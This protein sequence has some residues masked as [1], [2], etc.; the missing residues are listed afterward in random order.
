M[1][2]S[3]WAD[4]QTG[5]LGLDG[6]ILFRSIYT[7]N[8]DI[9]FLPRTTR[10]ITHPHFWSLPTP[11]QSLWS[12]LYYFWLYIR[13]HWNIVVNSQTNHWES[14]HLPWAPRGFS[15]DQ[16]Q[17][18]ISASGNGSIPAQKFLWLNLNWT[19]QFRSGQIHCWT[20]GIT[21]AI[22]YFRIVYL[23]WH[24]CSHSTVFMYFLLYH[25]NVH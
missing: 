19:G 6:L 23:L 14:I 2:W 13:L 21:D 9:T 12:K 8:F 4:L 25:S 1:G 5:S 16:A 15:P 22:L 7:Y 24:F 18:S 3:D 10:N 17:C 11:K 20:C